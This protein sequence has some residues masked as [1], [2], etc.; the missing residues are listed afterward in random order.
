MVRYSRTALVI[1][2][3][4]LVRLGAYCQD[5]TSITLHGYI[6][7]YYNSTTTADA[8]LGLL[9]YTTV[10]AYAEEIS[11][12]VAQLG[13][14]VQRSGVRG[15][16]T[17]HHGDI[18]TATWSEDYPVIQEA[19]IGFHLGREVWLD[20]GFFHTHVGAESFL[21]RYDRLSSTAYTTYNQPFYQAGLRLSTD[22]DKALYTEVWLVNGYNQFRDINSSKSLGLL[23]RYRH[24]EYWTTTYSGLYG[25]EDIAQVSFS[26]LNRYYHN[27]YIDYAKKQWHL[28]LSGDYARQTNS[29]IGSPGESGTLAS[30]ILS[31]GYNLSDKWR[32]TVRGERYNDH[33]AILTP[34]NSVPFRRGLELRAATLGVGYLPSPSSYVRLEARRSNS[35]NFPWMGDRFRTEVLITLGHWFD[36]ELSLSK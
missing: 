16:L 8:G 28:R 12:N 29:K 6:D 33:D 26:T 13:V 15:R 21:P 30:V 10:G 4:V 20:A 9:P 36:A 22:A 7:V 23:L 3:L 5:S 35:G 2:L 25:R 11:L 27:L 19:Q 14:S 32:L 31:V 17:L 24:N 34:P 1:T 18:A